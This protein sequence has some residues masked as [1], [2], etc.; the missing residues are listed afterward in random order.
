MEKVLQTM[1]T[2]NVFHIKFLLP[3]V[4]SFCYR[5][6]HETYKRR[7]RRKLDPGVSASI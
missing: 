7:N 5:R 6:L 1:F 3:E 4:L 2:N